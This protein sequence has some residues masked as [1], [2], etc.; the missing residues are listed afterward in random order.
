MDTT[1]T[2]LTHSRIPWTCYG[3]GAKS[4]PRDRGHLGWAAAGTMPV[5]ATD[6][7]EIVVYATST[8]HVVGH[9][10]YATE[11]RTLAI[12][13]DMHEC[14][15]PIITERIGEQLGPVDARVLRLAVTAAVDAVIA[16]A[17][18]DLTATISM[19]SS[20][21]AEVEVVHAAGGCGT[22]AVRRHDGYLYASGGEHLPGVVCSA[23]F[24]AVRALARELGLRTT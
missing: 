5:R 24:D 2:Q 10:C 22:L 8:A 14:D 19:C 7:D 1:T 4:I 3:R 11:R 18:S 16:L 17:P 9:L 15:P 12:G 23:A 6:A 13:G 20:T 21:L